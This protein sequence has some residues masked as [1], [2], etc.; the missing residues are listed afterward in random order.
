MFELSTKAESIQLTSSAL[1]DSC[2]LH[3]VI[4]AIEHISFH[5]FL[6]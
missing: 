3:H 4:E 6:R 1:S 2:L 5:V